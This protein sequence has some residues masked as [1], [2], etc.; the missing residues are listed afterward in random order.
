MCVDVCGTLCLLALRE[1]L[2][3]VSGSH[4]LHS[5]QK[6]DDWVL[7]L[8][9]PKTPNNHRIAMLDRVT[10]AVFWEE[11][12]KIVC[13]TIKVQKKSENT[14]VQNLETPPQIKSGTEGKNFGLWP[15]TKHGR[16]DS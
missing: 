9:D 14:S 13:S 15:T 11:S 8:V 10:L 2:W 6:K 1:N 12:Q 16:R 7:I 3:V 5:N 4:F